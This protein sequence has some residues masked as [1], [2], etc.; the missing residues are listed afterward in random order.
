MIPQSIM[1]SKGAHSDPIAPHLDRGGSSNLISPDA[2][3][4]SKCHGF[5]VSGY[6]VEAT[7]VEDAEMEQWKKD[8]PY[9]FERKY[10][11]DTGMTYETWVEE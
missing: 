7:K 9:A 10:D 4:S 5:V 3:I 8:Y 1:V 2:P 6:L 11:P